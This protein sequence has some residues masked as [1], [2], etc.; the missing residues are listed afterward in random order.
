M[1]D[2]DNSSQPQHFSENISVRANEINDSTFIGNMNVN[3]AANSSPSSSKK[4]A[5]TTGSVKEADDADDADDDDIFKEAP[6]P[7]K[8]HNPLEH[9]MKEIPDDDV[10]IHEKVSN[11][12]NNGEMRQANLHLMHVGSCHVISRRKDIPL[13]STWIHT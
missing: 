3:V 9:L 6:P 5:T 12:H 13:V 1:P 8:R 4:R 2:C 11:A 10:V 7:S